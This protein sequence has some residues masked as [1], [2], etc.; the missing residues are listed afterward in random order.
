MRK[1]RID[2]INELFTLIYRELTE[3]ERDILSKLIKPTKHKIK[4]V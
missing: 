2:K 3:E 4:V 1:P